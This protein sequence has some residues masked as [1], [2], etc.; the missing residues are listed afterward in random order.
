MKKTLACVL[1]VATV[2]TSGISALAVDTEYKDIYNGV[3]NTIGNFGMTKEHKTVI[4]YKTAE[5]D[6]TS[7]SNVPTDSNIYYIDQS[8][9]AFSSAMEIMLKDD[10]TPGY[11]CAMMGGVSDT[12][13][14]EKVNFIVGDFKV[15]PADILTIA[16]EA[17]PY[18]T[19]G[20]VTYYRKSFYKDVSFDEYNGFKS[21]KLISADGTRCI[22]AISFEDYPGTETQEGHNKPVTPQG[23]EGY[24]WNKT[25]VTGSGTMTIALQIYGMTVEEADSFKLYFSNE[26]AELKEAE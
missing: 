23:T 6:G 26:F 12:S 14:V 7:I 1:A 17:E 22:G 9:T 5:I 25:K 8:Q 19:D 10:L 20:G 3:S 11:Y 16:G 4:V 15:D 24:K 21:I 18:G 13:N 2:L